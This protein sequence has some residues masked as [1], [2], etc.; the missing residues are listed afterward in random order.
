[1]KQSRFKNIVSALLIL[2]HFVAIILVILSYFLKGFEFNQFTTTI[3]LIIPIFATYTTYIVQD[4]VKNKD[5]K[6]PKTEPQLNKIYIFT[7]IFLISLF[8]IYIISIIILKSMNAVLEDFDKFK[9]MLMLGEAMF[10][11]YIGKLISDLFSIPIKK[12]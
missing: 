11:V 12:P 2:S 10:G 1:M 9:T 3:G 7:T 4:M 8:S 5:I 6:P